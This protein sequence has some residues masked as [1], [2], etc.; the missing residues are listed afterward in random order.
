MLPQKI[1]NV[2]FT[3]ASSLIIAHSLH[4]KQ[5]DK[6]I[7][8][9]YNFK[10]VFGAQVD[11]R[12]GMFDFHYTL[13]HIEGN[14]GFG[15]SLTLI[16]QYTQS[17]A[18]DLYGLANRWSLNLTHFDLH[19]HMLTLSSGAS[20]RIN[21][22]SPSGLLTL[23]YSKLHD[24]AV[25][26]QTSTSAPYYIKVIYKDGHEEWLDNQGYLTKIVNPRGDSLTLRYDTS[27][28]GHVI[29]SITDDTG[30]N[31]ITFKQTGNQLSISR[32]NAA[33]ETVHTLM[34]IANG[35]I[36]QIHLPDMQD[37]LVFDHN[38]QSLIS[39]V[40]YPTGAWLHLTYTQLLGPSIPGYAP[41]HTPAV[42]QM[43]SHTN[44]SPDTDLTV[45]YTYNVIPGHNY[46][47]HGAN[48]PF[49]ANADLLFEAPTSYL[50]Q[51]SMDN[52][53]SKTIY[54]FNKFHLQTGTQTYAENG[55]LLASSTQCYQYGNGQQR[56]GDDPVPVP[57]ADLPANYTL[58]VKT[59]TTYYDPNDSSLSRSVTTT[60][61]YD[62]QGNPL[63]K[64]DA[65]GQ[66]TTYTYEA[67][68]GHGFVNFLHTETLTP[69]A[70]AGQTPPAAI[71]KTYTYH[72]IA[73]DNVIF[74]PLQADIA[75]QDNSG[76]WVT[77]QRSTHS[78]DL[79]PKHA[80]YTLPI[81]STL[82]QVPSQPDA[83][84]SV[85]MKTDYDFNKTITLAGKTYAVL[86][87]QKQFIDP[88][89]HALTAS[90]PDILTS[91][92]SL[93]TG[94]TLET[95][96]ARGAITGYVY[97]N[98]GRISKAIANLGSSMQA[99]KSY[100]YEMGDQQNALI[101]TAPN[102]Y[103]TR[104]LYDGLGHVL[105][106]DIQAFDNKNQPIANHW[107]KIATY[108]YN[109]YG[110]KRT[111]IQY[112]TNGLNQPISQTTTY[113][114]DVQ[115]RPILSTFSNGM[116]KVT[117]YDDV[118]NR[119]I[120]YTLAANDKIK[121]TA[122][123][124]CT[125]DGQAY[126]CLIQNFR[127]V[128]KDNGNNVIAKY[129]LAGDPAGKDD[130]GT[131]LYNATLRSEL[132]DSEAFLDKGMVLEPEAL[133]HWVDQVIKAKAYYSH[134]TMTYDGFKRGII[135]TDALGNATKQVFD[136]QGHVVRK[137]LP[138]GDTQFM[139]Y[140]LLDN[141]VSI[142]AVVDGKQ[143]VLG[144]RYY[145]QKNELMWEKDPLG[146]TRSY[147]YDENGNP[148]SETTPNGDV[149]LQTFNAMNKRTERRV[150]GDQGGT[151]TSHWQYDAATGQVTERQDA[152][153]TTQYHYNPR[154]EL[155]SIVHTPDDAQLTEAVP[156]YTISYTYTLA[157]KRKSV[158]DAANHTTQYQYDDFGRLAKVLY[159][160]H[161]NAKSHG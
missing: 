100:Q 117:V 77:Y 24:L 97:D 105:E 129:L 25:Y 106:K 82:A 28:G 96:D 114:Y 91:L 39:S 159:D 134:S 141:V 155:L 4:A 113:Q 69:A 87:S 19:S 14:K 154:G 18:T 94:Q 122:A 123:S 73:P 68:D 112:D 135:A 118:N 65:T 143:K 34:T 84:N 38:N 88:P 102:K 54:T 136:A 86:E 17:A 6:A 151:Y 2:L 3:I 149:I 52:G 138:N 157:G 131:P 72:K 144:T 8:N 92:K 7:S 59:I 35:M 119:T 44:A 30:K 66:T 49:S 103:Q 158:T 126:G 47:A 80:T 160:D 53:L 76:K 99:T 108:T 22:L 83:L 137:V 142:G 95:I 132:S 139:T 5:T 127:V 111:E 75:Y 79:D 31:A 11:P 23:Q 153:G 161:S 9:A 10:N 41:Y 42:S 61:H 43:T 74:L 27:T 98:I 56:C 36:T 16:A 145:N 63:Q 26:K 51:T 48:V 133:R 152:T 150:Q 128:D 120:E 78:Y 50:Y 147:A 148:I 107:D 64:T 55:A 81:S 33:G 58:P 146:N 21:N 130:Q 116:A 71:K 110:N 89:S 37:P 125:I 104:M 109:R 101:V 60:T 85:N 67:P 57:F 32:F 62:D 46:L 156:A 13:A 29:Q 93:Y 20:F 15:P 70:V 90:K 12:T 121:L 45:N 140:D 115:Q 124:P 40:H 1:R